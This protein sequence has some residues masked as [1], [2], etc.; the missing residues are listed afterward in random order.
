VNRQTKIYID[1]LK[2]NPQKMQYLLDRGL[3]IETIKKFGI[4]LSLSK[5]RELNN[6]MADKDRN[7]E[8]GFLRQEDKI[9]PFFANRIMIPFKSLDGK[10][11]IGFT[12]R[13]IFSTNDKYLTAQERSTKRYFEAQDYDIA[14]YKNSIFN[15]SEYLYNLD[16]LPEKCY[17][18]IISE[19]QLNTVACDQLQRQGVKF[20]LDGIDSQV[21]PISVGG[22]SFTE[23]HLDLLI[24]KGI[25]CITLCFD[26]DRAGIMATKRAIEMILKRKEIIC[27]SVIS[28]PPK[29]DMMDL[30]NKPKKVK[31]LVSKIRFGEQWLCDY[32]FHIEQKEY[33]KSK[34]F[35]N[36]SLLLEFEGIVTTAKVDLVGVEGNSSYHNYLN[37]IIEQEYQFMLQQEEQRQ[38]RQLQILEEKYYDK[39]I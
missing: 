8:K 39:N 3:T 9:K 23:K 2:N 4:G 24:A 36:H 30:I 31:E 10:R 19:A 29:E 11:V 28:M 7:L 38:I 6:L 37:K 18:V 33:R 16:A 14:K 34:R 25:M 35:C 26:G 15:K 32:Y 27:V 1:N 20:E 21:H 13:D 22:T 12:G 5:K 17:T